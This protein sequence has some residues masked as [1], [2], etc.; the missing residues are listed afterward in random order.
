MR[1][2]LF[3]D[4]KKTRRPAHESHTRILYRI[5]T[6]VVIVPTWF[7]YPPSLSCGGL[8]V[9]CKKNIKKYVDKYTQK[10]FFFFFPAHDQ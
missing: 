4:R 10:Y 1:D 5:W 8:R 6:I 9:L 3:G 7:P 2:K